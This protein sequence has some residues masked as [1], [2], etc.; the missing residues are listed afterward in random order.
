[1]CS[2]SVSRSETGTGASS[3]RGSG[4]NGSTFRGRSRPTSMGSKSASGTSWTS[5]PSKER[6]RLRRRAACAVARYGTGYNAVP[7]CSARQRCD[8]AGLSLCRTTKLHGGLLRVLHTRE[9]DNKRIIGNLHV[10]RLTVLYAAS[11]VGKSSVLR[12]GVMSRLHD[13]AVAS[14]AEEAESIDVPVVFAAWSSDPIPALIDEIAAAAQP[15]ATNPLEL[16]HDSLEDAIDTTTHAAGGDLLIV[17][18]QFEEYFT[19][20]SRDRR[21]NLFAGQLAQ[22]ISRPDLR[23]HFLISIR[24]TLARVGELLKSRAERLRQYLH[25]EH[26][27]ESAARRRDRQADR[28]LERVPRARRSL[29]GRVSSRGCGCEAGAAGACTTG[30]SEPDGR[31]GPPHRRR[32]NRGDT[33]SS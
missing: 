2:F 33:S 25:L 28:A 24:S 30:D 6:W 10:A 15:F 12:A 9:D 8:G 20:Q 16:L 17:L 31:A 4:V 18:D 7:T 13:L 27:D 21:D 32:P 19:Y 5:T 3:C 29:R 14:S 11:G 1:M 22:C 26:L 23:A